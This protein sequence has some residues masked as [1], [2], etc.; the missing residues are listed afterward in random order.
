MLDII[1]HNNHPTWTPVYKRLNR[2]NGAKT[3]SEDIIKFYVPV[4]EKHFEHN[5]QKN[6]L[7]TVN[8]AWDTVYSKYKQIFLF[9]HE[10]G[11]N[12]E[13]RQ[14]RLND[15][16]LFNKKNKH[17]K[18]WFIVWSQ[19][20]C[21]ELTA[22]NLNA[23]Y[24][25]M[26]I[27]TQKFIKYRDYPK[28]YDNRIIYFGNIIGKKIKP[29]NELWKVCRRKGFGLDSISQNTYN[30]GF[31]K[32]NKPAIYK[33]ISRYKYGVGVGR[34]AQEMSAMGL[35]VFCYG[36]GDSLLPNEKNREKILSQN[37]TSW[38]EGL[39][40]DELGRKMNNKLLDSLAPIN[41]DCR[42]VAKLLDAILDGLF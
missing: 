4:F 29:F 13:I 10:R 9:V 6:L 42:E 31:F 37:C 3:Y 1:D 41:L 15:L 39:P 5:R 11:I 30:N 18:V 14:I 28:F 33:L 2:E 8:N 22:N 26:A 7:I 24:L 36:Y 16:K 32:L 34:S 27:D 20:Q 40:L 12:E 21:E 35:K 17:A 19:Q 25:P 23:I 38:G